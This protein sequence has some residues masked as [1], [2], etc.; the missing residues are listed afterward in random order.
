MC[1]WKDAAGCFETITSH[2]G[3]CLRLSSLLMLFLDEGRTDIEHGC[4]IVCGSKGKGVFF[5]CER[6]RE[7]DSNT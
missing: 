4:A 7:R 5:Y 3:K 1:D 6:E 2:T